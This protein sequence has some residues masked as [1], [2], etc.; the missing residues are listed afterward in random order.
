MAR[1]ARRHRRP[2]GLARGARRPRLP[3]PGRPS[4]PAGSGSAGDDVDPDHGRDDGGP[5]RTGTFVPHHG[6]HGAAGGLGA[7][8]DV[9]HRPARRGLR[10]R[11]VGSPGRR[12][13][14][15][16]DGG[17]VDQHR[18]RA[19]P[20]RRRHD[21]REPARA[22]AGRAHPHARPPAPRTQ[23]HPPDHRAPPA[24]RHDPGLRELSARHRRAVR[25]QA[26]RHRDRH[27]GVQPL[28]AGHDRP[29]RR[30]TR[31]AHR[32]R[33][34]C[35]RTSHHRSA[36]QTFQARAQGHDRGRGALTVT[37]DPTR[38]LLSID[39]LDDDEHADLDQWGH[40]A[41]LTESAPATSIPELFAAQVTRRA[42]APA[43]TFDGRS[44]TYRELDEASNRLAHLLIGCGAEPG[45]CVAVL[46]ERCA[47][48]VIAIL[49]ILK[50][51]AAYLPIDPA[52][53]K[54]RIDFMVTDGAPVAAVTTTD[55]ADR[56]AD[57]DLPVIRVDDTTLD[58]L[59]ATAPA[60]GP[61][62]EDIA[63]IIY[64][65]GTTGKP[66]G[67]AVSHHN[68]T[69]LF[70][71]IDVGV[72]MSP[73]QV[74][75]QCH[76]YAFDYSVWEMWGALL[77]GGRLV[78]VPATVAAAPRDFHALLLAEHVTV[79]SQTPTALT[80]L[81]TDGLESVAVM[82][83]GEACPPDV[84]QR[85][86]PGRTMIN[87]YGPTETTVYATISAPLT[88][89]VTVVPIGTPVPG[90]A[91]FVLDRWMRP[92]PAGVVGELYVAGRGVGVGYV[93]RPGLTASRFVACP[94][95]PGRRMYRTGDLVRWGADGQLQYLGRADDQV[96]I[97]GYRIELGEVRAALAGLDGVE[98]AVVIV[99]EDQPGTK[100]LVGY[101]TQAESTTVDPAALR[102]A[103]GDRLPPYMVPAA[104]VVMDT[105]P[106]TVNGKLDTAALPA[107]EFRDHDTY[108]APGTA[109][110]ET[111]AG[112]F[113][114]VLDVDRV[115]V[116][117]S[118]FDLG[119]DSILAMRL[120][121]AINNA[122]DTELPVGALFETPTVARLAPT[123]TGATGTR[124]PLRQG[125]RPAVVPLSFAQR[126]M[127]MIDQLQGPSAV[128]NMAVALE[129][130]GR[131]DTGALAAAFDDVIARHESLR[132][133]FPE[134]DGVPR[135]QVLAPTT[136][137]AHHWRVVDAAGW[138]ESDLRRAVEAVAAETFDLAE[139]IPLRTCLFR[140]SEVCHVL[141][142]V[143]H[144]I[145]ADGWSVAP[146]VRDL[147]AAYTARCA[148][149]APSWPELP[150]Q[151]ADYTLW[152]RTRL[153]DLDDPD[154][155]ISAQVAYWRAALAGMPEQ[156]A[157]P[158]D[159]PYPLVADHRGA[160]VT[161]AWSAELHQQIRDTAVA[162]H[163]TGF[164][165]VHAA[166]AVLLSRLSGSPDV[167]VGFPIAGRSDPALEDL[168]GFFVNTLVLRVEVAGDP[169][170]AEVLAQVRRRSLAAYEHQDVP[171]EVLVER[172][173]PVR[174]LTRHPLVQ[175][176]LAW[177]TDQLPERFGL[178]GLDV[179]QLP[180]HSHTARTDLSFA[181]SERF[182]DAGAPAGIVGTVEFRTDVF[183]TATVEAM[184]ARLQRVVTAMVADPEGRVS[185]VEVLDNADH[186]RLDRLGN[187]AAL[188]AATTAT[189]VPDLFA[190]Q[191]ARRP[192]DVAVRCDGRSL[193]YRE[194]AEASDRLARRLVEHG[195]APGTVVALLL[196][197]SSAA[198]GAMLA[199][200]KAGAAYLA[201]D[202]SLPDS[203]IAFMLSDADPVAIV[204]TEAQRDRAQGRP[205]VAL[206]DVESDSAAEL[207]MVSPG[208]L[209]YLIY[210]SG[211]TGT[212][213]AVAVTHANLA[214]LA[215]SAPAALP[216]RPVWTQCHSYA[217][218]FSVWEIWAALLGGGRLV[219]VPDDVVLS[220]T[221]FT[222]L[223][224]DE[225]ISV[226]TQT[227]S[228]ITALD[229]DAVPPTAVLLG[230]EACPADVVDRW[231]ADRTLINAYGPT[232]ITVY[233][234]MSAPLSPGSGAAP[235]GGPVPTTA[236]FVLDERL[237]P[238]PEGTVGE[239]Y[240]AGPGVT[241][242]Y[243]GRT[244][245]TAS[246]FVAC[247][248]GRPGARM[249]RTGDLVRWRTD[250]AL[251]YL[252]RADDQVKIR[253]Y[254]IELGEVQAALA[255]LDG[256]RAA[257]VI[258]RQDQPG[259][260]RLVGYITGTAD[261]AAARR[262]LA[263]TLPPYLVPAA[264][265]G[266]D[267]LPLTVGGKLDVRALPAPVLEAVDEYRAPTDAVEEVL[268]G[269]FAQV[270]GRDRVGVD[271]SFFDLGGDSILSMQVVSQARAAGLVCRARDVFVEQTVARL[272]RVVEIASTT[273]TSD[274]DGVG[275]VP[276][277]PIMA[278]LR[279]VDGPT[280]EF[281]QTVLVQAPAGATRSA[282][283]LLLQALLDRHPM[284]R[285]RVDDGAPHTREPGA[286]PAAECL[287]A[288]DVLDVQAIATARA[289]LN[290][291]DGAMLSAVW[292]EATG[293]LALIVHHLAIDAVSWRI[294]LEDLNIAWAQ[295]RSGQPIAV[296]GEGTSFAR[297][298]ALL[299]D[300]A[301]TVL[302]D[303]GAW[304]RV[305]TAP[306]LLPPPDV[307][308]DT[309]AGAGRHTAAWDPSLTR[310]LLG[311]VPA[312]FH[313]GITD[314]LLIALALACA[315]FFD[316]GSPVSIDVEGHGRHEDL[317]PGVD[318]SRTVGWFT[319][320]YPVALSVGRLRWDTVRSGDAALGA[321][322]KDAKE[323]LRALPDG[324][325]YG[326]LRYLHPDSNLAGRDP[327][328]G[329]NYLGQVGGR[330]A[331][332]PGGL[333]RPV[334]DPWAT[335]VG[336]AIAMPL[337]HSVELSAATV[338]TGTGPQLQ[339]TWLWARS[340]LPDTTIHRLGALFFDALT[341][342]CAH[343]ARGGGGL[344]PSDVR[345]ASLSQQRIDELARHHRIADVLP[346]TPLQQGLLF[347]ATTAR[348]HVDVYAM[349]LDVTIT[350]PLDPERL[351]TAVQAVVRRHPNLAA[352][353]SGE[354]DPPIQVIPADPDIN[355]QYRN[356][357]SAEEITQL[358]ADERAAVC[359][360][361]N[362]PAFRALVIK[363]GAE[364]HR[365][366]LTNHHI[367]LD[368]WSLPI[369]LQ[370][371]FAAYAGHRL[372]P[373]GSFRRYVEWLVTR[374]RDAAADA[375]RE[376][377]GGVDTPTLVPRPIGS[378]PGG[379][380]R[381]RPR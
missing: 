116:D 309:Y 52:H 19:R 144:H 226:L 41:V 16:F 76:S 211:T 216:D 113:A 84:V 100:R 208:D 204:T 249:Y 99:R 138:S 163:A 3:H 370:D 59:P 190:A 151:Y 288:V 254:R 149:T 185:A 167:A 300:H 267:E 58:G 172:L 176:L 280:D 44:W 146:L 240:V 237:R 45:A 205:V 236:L 68:V 6:E 227:P 251:H 258:A 154:S 202:P 279:H 329:F 134:A 330:T 152:Q 199:I 51:G 108:R 140:V 94:F 130:R 124:T 38:R 328:I 10:H 65:S 289:R 342:I 29:A 78:V 158:T 239:L 252:G 119:G 79:L 264:V 55:L 8:A 307:T 217:F 61:A 40:R 166:L 69:R 161:I 331:D 46:M 187:R 27:P 337:G 169:T 255:A 82:V 347:H 332:V 155:L 345:P 186:D 373:A 311:E 297:W 34:R 60:H 233:A 218:D 210:T 37:A 22:A 77:H 36:D 147:G 71:A 179:T 139:A 201:I 272:A 263:E 35:V 231:A 17:S 298:A 287:M 47:Q 319:T 333:W 24:V 295:H 23:R 296:T 220:P 123:V 159:R 66:K 72:A 194:L 324:L 364:R 238:V 96:K 195:A 11:G 168:I 33:H 366:V 259:T 348:E 14:R 26:G 365:V 31:L 351:C 369:L 143:V 43:L 177:Q 91:L 133:V 32:I 381:R 109:V 246:R 157:L 321:V 2:A 73:D 327:G 303:A 145:A 62:P 165:V 344:T 20:H 75:T 103:L 21:G 286:V 343:V 275:P 377:L 222:A 352:R 135:Q 335:D 315:E 340:K 325:S 203:R 54:T 18:A 1:R 256:V 371:I 262:A 180:V 132:T 106:M 224:R 375:W 188:W 235:L 9:A 221:E 322:I 56:F 101:V 380:V 247:P 57:P 360:L 285:L 228:A 334:T 148:A 301:R 245:L 74:W 90:A 170:V 53:P 357:R 294:L 175:V 219:V 304:H 367:V 225:D 234:A 102:N 346:L 277:T 293:Q 368:G 127:W 273:T 212:P 215:A 120:V 64:T 243:L 182:T 308:S 214:H 189:S 63:H 284:L 125:E 156:I 283:V 174:S 349:Q 269:I 326:L 97:R 141:V 378:D 207:P 131:L 7:A 209:A 253:G 81:P 290:P 350:G 98:H 241:A 30:G 92:V 361:T 341:G 206:D 39:L 278:W 162:H 15:G 197:R 112:L 276:P 312:A 88:A 274:D 164:M 87:G 83:A 173:S 5:D 232:E 358:C 184:A 118:F 198:V 379:A 85:W 196:P 257:A 4:R 339:V 67:V 80:A 49:A 121:A 192:D 314:I 28:P 86:A 336:S 171:F 93:R 48:A 270:L 281:N 271:D 95:D 50:A 42:D 129:L 282:V 114:R 353:F 111:L 260:S 200:L 317:F 191:A 261:P 104:V 128:Y 160:A 25:G 107:P 244:A 292:A 110:E 306:A 242:G 150:V 126:R 359:D 193:T 302:D 372:P 305:E 265:V 122:L 250:G 299:V 213:K 153:G 136:S 89:A 142:G 376:V 356:L 268:A 316:T 117:D 354:S 338:D 310:Q 12:A 248:F 355:W 320:K 230:G 13:G 181:L 223:M 183:D 137:A 229:P 323:Q 363:I 362:G 313:A 115:G 105:L 70:Q 374:D 291:A 318:L 178:G 266:V